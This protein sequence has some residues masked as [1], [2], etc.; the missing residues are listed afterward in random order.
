MTVFHTEWNEEHRDWQCRCGIAM[1]IGATP[2]EAT[3]ACLKDLG[4]GF[5]ECIGWLGTPEPRKTAVTVVW[6]GNAVGWHAQFSDRFYN[7]GR[8]GY[9][10][11]PEAATL[12]LMQDMEAL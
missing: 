5:A 7:C 10:S 2:E 4:N 8:F 1:G 6:S 11:T 9:G 12:A 3:L